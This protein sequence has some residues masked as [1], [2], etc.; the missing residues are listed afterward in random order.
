ME[1]RYRRSRKRVNR[2]ESIYFKA[3][4]VIPRLFMSSRLFINSKTLVFPTVLLH[5][6]IC[7]V[8]WSMMPYNHHQSDDNCQCQLLSH[9]ILWDLT[10]SSPPG[11]S[12]HGILQTRILGWVAIPFSRGSFPTQGSNPCLLCLLRCRWILYQLGHQGSLTIVR[13]LYKNFH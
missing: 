11:S 10:D 1:R 2:H 7:C 8:L 3:W 9:V 5:G 4:R 13:N 6:K 12:V